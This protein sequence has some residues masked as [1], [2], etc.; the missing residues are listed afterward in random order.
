MNQAAVTSDKVVK[1]LKAAGVTDANQQ[2]T[3]VTLN[4]QYAYSNGKPPRITGYQAAVQVRARVTDLAK[5]GDVIKAGTDAG[6]NSVSG[7]N[8]TLSEENPTKFKALDLA[9]TD[10]K[11]KAE[12]LAKASGRSLGSCDLPRSARSGRRRR[13]ARAGPQQVK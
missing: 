7:P 10:A 3:G 5:I 11:A 13:A 8:F 4:P 9:V 2:T 6:A 1:A 12:S